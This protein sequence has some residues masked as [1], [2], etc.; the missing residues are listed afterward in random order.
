VLTFVLP[1]RLAF[2]PLL[3]A[4]C[5]MPLGQQMIIGGLHFPILRLLILV[6]VVRVISRGEARGLAWNRMDKVFFWWAVLSVILG[7]LSKPTSGVFVNRL[8]AIY[9]AVGIY[10]L[11]SCWVGDAETFLGLVKVLAVMMVP[12]AVSMVVEKFTARNIFSILGGVPAI[13]IERAGHL[14]CQA[15]FRHPILAGTF[16]ATAFPLFVGLWFQGGKVKK[17]AMLGGISACAI[18]IAASSGGALVTLLLSWVGFAFWRLRQRMRLVRRTILV[19][20][21][22]LALVMNA[23]VWYLTARLSGIAGGTGWYRGWLIDQAVA[24]FDEWWL[25]GTTYTANWSVTGGEV[26]DDDPDNI[27]I[28]NQFLLE[29]IKGGVL[30]MALFIALIVF[31]FKAVGRRMQNA[32]GSSLAYGM[33]LWATGVS[34]FTHCIS[35]FSVTYYDQLAVIWYWLLAV[36]SRIAYDERVDTAQEDESTTPAQEMAIG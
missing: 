10:F 23:P 25:C 16:G 14:R 29:G 20:I 3:A 21:L 31:C 9:Y 7:T 22:L 17:L 36:I 24:H 32:T 5:Y 13:T 8:G 15:A 12:I 33:L 35:F 11:V 6:G 19:T 18:T 27:D 26:L 2:L 34:V 28:T 30:K 4:V 1:R